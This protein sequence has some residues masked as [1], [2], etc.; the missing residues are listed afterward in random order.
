MKKDEEQIDILLRQNESEQLADV[1]WNR[2]HS[3]ISKRLDR[4]DRNKT[5]LTSYRYVYKIAAGVVAS[6]AVVFIAVIIKINLPKEVQ[7]DNGGKAIVTFVESEG[8]A[9]VEIL[10]SGKRD[11]QE[12]GRP[13]W[14]II[15]KSEPKVADNGQNRDEADF[16][17]LM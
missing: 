15:R 13:T 7:F 8:S 5:S 3:S 9:R 14:S 1:D 11:I 12:K 10:E 16:A 4:A 2:L 6:A 17:C